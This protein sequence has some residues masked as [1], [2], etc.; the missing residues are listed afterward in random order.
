MGEVSL[1]CID[2]ILRFQIWRKIVTG[3]SSHACDS[4]TLS[5]RHRTH[6]S[7]AAKSCG[8]VDLE[9]APGHGGGGHSRGVKEVCEDLWG[10]RGGGRVSMGGGV[11]SV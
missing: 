4:T 1:T 10:P 7:S 11:V 8:D 5:F 2:F 9:G 3:D 6:T